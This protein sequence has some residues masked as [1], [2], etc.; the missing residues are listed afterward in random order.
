MKNGSTTLSPSLYHNP[1]HLQTKSHQEPATLSS[2]SLLLP[3]APSLQ[4]P[5]KCSD[6]ISSPQQIH[7]FVPAT[8]LTDFLH[9]LQPF[10]QPQQQQLP[11]QA[12]KG[13][14]TRLKVEKSAHVEQSQ[15][16]SKRSSCSPKGGDRANGYSASTNSS[17]IYK[18][19]RQRTGAKVG[20][21]RDEG[22]PGVKAS[23][24]PKLE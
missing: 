6:A 14:L 7:Y 18:V 24:R 15:L 2:H 17:L 1:H 19:K 21:E 4:I 3:T 9:Q 12:P 16:K 13:N 23:K 11:T 22:E 5:P 10:S 8:A 20:S